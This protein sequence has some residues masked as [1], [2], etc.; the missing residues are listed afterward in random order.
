MSGRTTTVVNDITHAHPDAKTVQSARTP[1]ASDITGLYA[2]NRAILMSALDHATDDDGKAAA[3]IGV[4]SEK[5]TRGGLNST[6]LAAYTGDLFSTVV[7]RTGRDDVVELVKAANERMYEFRVLECRRV[8]DAAN[9]LKRLCELLMDEYTDKNRGKL[10][11]A[12]ALYH[13]RRRGL[14]PELC[15]MLAAQKRT[16]FV[17]SQ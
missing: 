10:R 6:T 9:E 2:L 3:A 14:V 8:A 13:D 15:G 12:I 5:L 7:E 16:S 4:L 17:W 1:E 11:A